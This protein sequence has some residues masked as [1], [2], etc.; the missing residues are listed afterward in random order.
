VETPWK[1]DTWKTRRE[2]RIS[3]MWIL[4]K[5]EG[6]ELDGTELVQGHVLF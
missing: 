2:E 5:C 3:L 1:T 4:G 6:W